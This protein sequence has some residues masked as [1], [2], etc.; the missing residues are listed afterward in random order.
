MVAHPSALLGSIG[1]WL[2][3]GSSLIILSRVH[4]CVTGSNCFVRGSVSPKAT[5]IPVVAVDIGSV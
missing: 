5:G 2:L 4:P 1:D 3:L